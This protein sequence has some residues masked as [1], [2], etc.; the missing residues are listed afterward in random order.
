MR[1]NSAPKSDQ[2]WPLLLGLCKYHS[3]FG[4]RA[5]SCLQPCKFHN[6]SGMGIRPQFLVTGNRPQFSEPRKRHPVSEP[7]NFPLFDSKQL[8]G[9]SQQC[10]S[11]CFRL[12][13]QKIFPRGHRFRSKHFALGFCKSHKTKQPPSHCRQRH[14]HKI[15]WH[16]PNRTSIGVTKVYLALHCRRSHTTHIRRRFPPIT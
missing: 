14:P 15:V 9:R 11:P 7:K 2:Q 5:R 4:D 16:P 6:V 3:K 1:R 10:T 8:V 12:K 13:F